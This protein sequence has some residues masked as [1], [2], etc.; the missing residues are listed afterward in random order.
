MAAPKNLADD[1]NDSAKRFNERDI[2]APL[3]L[4]KYGLLLRF[5]AETAE[6]KEQLVAALTETALQGLDARASPGYPGWLGSGDRDA[7]ASLLRTLEGAESLP[8]LSAR[9][10]AALA[11]IGLKF[12]SRAESVENATDRN[13]LTDYAKLCL[14]QADKFQTLIDQRNEDVSTSKTISPARR[15]VLKKD[16]P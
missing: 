4:T 9:T 6:D 10:P 1:F 3:L 2:G 14:E 12:V 15:I 13:T 5:Q 16:G 7:M 8:H 11:G